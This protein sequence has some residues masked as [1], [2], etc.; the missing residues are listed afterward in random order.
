[1]QAGKKVI[2]N[3][4]GN[5]N[6]PDEDS[7]CANAPAVHW[8]SGYMD[9]ASY[10][11]PQCMLE[12]PSR[13]SRDARVP[14]D[15]KNEELEHCITAAWCGNTEDSSYITVCCD[16]LWWIVTFVFYSWNMLVHM[17]RD[18]LRDGQKMK[19]T[20][21]TGDGSTEKYVIYRQGCFPPVKFSGF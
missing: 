14:N 13:R 20:R 18:R 6:N 1:M 15:A 17:R 3:H 11:V 2:D 9:C 19:K 16:C 12:G 8:A 7:G 4:A 21:T 5:E 10:V